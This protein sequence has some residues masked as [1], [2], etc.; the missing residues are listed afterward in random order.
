MITRIQ[1][2]KPNAVK[3]VLDKVFLTSPGGCEQG[4][5]VATF[6]ANSWFRVLSIKH[7][8]QSED[9]SGKYAVDNKGHITTTKHSV[10]KLATSVF[11]TACCSGRRAFKSHVASE[12]GLKSRSMPHPVASVQ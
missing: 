8:W 9:V 3:N 10:C 2:C 6:S 4:L 7:C 12:H 11:R 5:Y 1:Q